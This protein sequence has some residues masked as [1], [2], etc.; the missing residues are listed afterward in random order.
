MVSTIAL[1]A[2][3]GS[4]AYAAVSGIPDAQGVFHGCVNNSTGV[5][6]VV[7]S[8][9]SCTHR[10]VIR[11]GGKRIVIP[12][13]LAIAWNQ[14]GP[15]GLQG[16]QGAQ[17]SQGQQ[18]SQGAQGAQGAQGGQGPQGIQ[19][20]QGTE[21]T[22]GP[23]ATTFATTLAQG[24]SLQTLVNMNNG[25]TLTGSCTTAPE[26]EL[27]IS[28]GSDVAQGSGTASFN[29]GAPVAFDFDST[30]DKSIAGSAS[31]DVDVIARDGTTGS[32]FVRIDAHGTFG[33]PCQFYGTI[34]P[35]S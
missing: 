30:G 19:G 25:L 13:E 28:P 6:R 23:G 15:R 33:N 5:L 29:G 34:T 27:T 16:G 35:S 2:A 24:S 11:R 14:Q 26:V 3:L 9:Q 10:R 4:G 31:V 18:G 32:S 20:Q 21:G 8:A 22:Q 12:G 7:K 17:G 1:V